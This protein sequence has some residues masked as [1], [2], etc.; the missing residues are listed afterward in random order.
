M[1][2]IDVYK[3]IIEVIGNKI[4]CK[5]IEYNSST[6]IARPC[7]KLDMTEV[8]EAFNEGLSTYSLIFRL[9]YFSDNKSHIEASNK[10]VQR[11]LKELLLK[12]LGVTAENGVW[13]NRIEW[14]RTATG[15]LVAEWQTEITFEEIV[16]DEDGADYLEEIDIE[17]D[18]GGR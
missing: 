15:E 5:C 6:P 4:G 7:F 1:T 16:T 12:P 2:S 10:I 8:D 17:I 18:E 13:A 11:K 3:K 14:D 9:I